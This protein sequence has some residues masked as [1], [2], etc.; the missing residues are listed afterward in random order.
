MA[1]LQHELAEAFSLGVK[2]TRND[3]SIRHDRFLAICTWSQSSSKMSHRSNNGT[4]LTSF[5]SCLALAMTQDD[6][7]Y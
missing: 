2:G 3:A 1:L 6:S 7:D 4:S 5:Q